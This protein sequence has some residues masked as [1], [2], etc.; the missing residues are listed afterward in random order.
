M[1][2]A[3]ATSKLA[4]E[5]YQIVAECEGKKNI[6]PG[7]LIK[8]MQEKYGHDACSKEDCKKAIR[9]LIDSGRCIY[10]YLGESYIQ[11]PPKQDAAA[12]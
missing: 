8:A 5:M 2:E 10:T 11:L 3:I 6:K 7:D 9:E 4:Q 1:A 12:G